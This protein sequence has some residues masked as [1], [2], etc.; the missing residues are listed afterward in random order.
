MSQHS[1]GVVKLAIILQDCHSL[2]LQDV[3][4]AFSISQGE[5]VFESRQ[6][7]GTWKDRHGRMGVE[8]AMT[9]FVDRFQQHQAQESISKSSEPSPQ[10]PEIPDFSCFRDSIDVHVL[11]MV[12]LSEIHAMAVL[13]TKDSND[14]EQIIGGN[15]WQMEDED[16]D[17]DND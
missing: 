1:D 2:K 3:R 7:S 15:E 8:Q 6:S 14:D 13:T 16:D 17:N 11:V 10:Q 5:H 4:V 12:K 9:T